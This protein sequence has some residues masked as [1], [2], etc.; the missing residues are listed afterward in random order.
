MAECHQAWSIV[1]TD[2]MPSSWVDQVTQ[3]IDWP[4]ATPPRHAAQLLWQRGF[5][6]LG[7]LRGFLDPH[8]YAPTAAAAFG[9]DM[10]WAVQR[11]LQACDRTEKVAIWGDFDADGVTAT[12]VLW[13]GLGQLFTPHDQLRYFIPNRL[14]DSH[15]L[16]RH[17]LET[18]A[19]WGCSLVVTCDTGSTSLAELTYAGEL[20]LDVIVTDHHTLPP[21]R[22]PVVAIINPRSL[23]WQHPLAT[24][25]GV[26]V[27]YKLV[28]ALY[29][30]LPE[31]PTYPVESLLDLVAIGLIADLVELRGDSRYLAQVGIEHLQR[32]VQPGHDSRR[33][34]IAALLRFCKRMGDRPTDI[35]FGI[36]PRINAVSRIHGD[37]S[38]CVELLTSP[39][40]DQCQR[41][42]AEAELAN[43]RRKALQ[44]DV[45]AQVEQQLAAVDLATS[46]AIVL[47]NEQWPA[48]VL[49]LVAGQVAQ[50][51]GRPTLLLRLDPEPPEGSDTIRLARGSARS[52]QGLDL[53]Q[54]MQD[55]SHLLHHFGGHPQAAGLSLPAENVPL[56]AAALN[57]Q[58]REQ[59][60]PLSLAPPLPVDLVVTV[61]ELG[62]S[63][64][65]QLKLLEPYGMGN[66]VPRLLVRQA[67]F[68]NG[69]HRN[70]RDL[71][72]GKLRYIKTEF[73]LWDD[74][75]QQGFPGEW[76]GHYQ[77]ELP[78]GRC[79]ALVELDF[80]AYKRAAIR[81]D[82][83]RL[84]RLRDL[85][86]SA[87][88][89]GAML[90][91][92]RQSQEM[93]SALS[94]TTLV[95]DQCPRP[96]GVATLVAEATAEQRPLALAYGPPS[97]AAPLD[98]W[99]MLVGMA[100]YLSRVGKPVRRSHLLERLQIC[101][102]SLDIGLDCLTT[103]GFT[104]Q[105]EGP[106]LIIQQRSQ[107]L[108]PGRIRP[109]LAA[110]QEEAFRRHYFYQVPPEILQT[111]AQQSLN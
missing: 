14:T 108:T 110:L 22:P 100:K 15:G 70:I 49:G 74:T 27:A 47:A 60:G 24:L 37:A 104:I 50:R 10:Q 76:W 107:P 93:V 17:G 54:L 21:R 44:R 72:G 94:S 99:T 98:T 96:G 97:S 92:Q 77:D 40:P 58:L 80:D 45:M 39:D 103:M 3:V 90:M 28:E 111:M 29:Q 69:C 42:A 55:H 53:Y 30:A 16:N 71:Q 81:C 32:H 79:D 59:L 57:R 67:W 26:A 8:Q 43:S 64:F 89:V 61:A 102:R 20:G 91:D 12:A 48:G 56:L 1:A 95:V 7:Q 101:D 9:D 105:P 83:W 11:L 36:G 38:F 68:T 73:M 65:R 35:S 62:K 82:W 23:P 51:Y 31:P 4:A 19:A 86:D 109:F 25:S 66:P 13:D 87:A 2:A 33:P 41:L 78:P 46:H 88:V 5:R 18:L 52:V 75:A 63:L 84:G 34:G 106:E 6:D 85:D